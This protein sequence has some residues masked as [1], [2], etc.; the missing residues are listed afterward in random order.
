MVGRWLMAAYWLVKLVNV[1]V[2][3]LL[4]TGWFIAHGSWLVDTGYG[5]QVPHVSF[6]VVGSASARLKMK[7]PEPGPTELVA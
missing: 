7:W 2:I 4:A 3:E 6:R 5:I 1:L